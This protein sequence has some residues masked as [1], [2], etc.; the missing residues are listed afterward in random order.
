MTIFIEKLSFEKQWKKIRFPYFK[1][2]Y[3]AQRFLPDK[4]KGLNNS[5]FQFSRKLGSVERKR[6]NG[7]RRISR[8][9]EAL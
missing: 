6:S 5:H 7:L 4:W 9:Y 2:S 1:K 3:L 8:T